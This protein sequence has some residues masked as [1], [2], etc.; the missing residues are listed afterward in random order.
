MS[1]NIK[2][3][4]KS[5]WR[6][7]LVHAARGYWGI[8]I[9][10][11]LLFLAV[12]SDGVL[13]PN[14]QR[15]FIALFEQTPDAY[16]SFVMHA[17]PTVLLIVVS[18]ILLD[19][20][21]I[22]RSLTL[23]HWRPKIHNQIS[24]ILTGYVQQQ[25]M[26]YWTGRMPGK[27]NSQISYVADGF[28]VISNFM[29]MIGASA[30]I[31][32]NVGLILGINA[33]VA[34]IFAFV[35]VF[36]LIYGGLLIRPMG[37][38]AKEASA[39]GSHLS[40]K[41]VDS[42]SNYS[43]VKLFAG[44]RAEKRYLAEP[45]QKRI[46][47]QMF[48]MFVQRLFWAVPTLVWDIAFGCTMLLC[49]WLFMQG[50]ILVSEIVFTTSVFFSVMGT[51]SRIVNQIPDIVDKLGSAK[52]AYDELNIALT[53]TDADNA[54]ALHVTHGKIEFR[55]VW[56]KYKSK[57]VLRDF[58]LTIKPGESVGIVGASG[59]GKTTLVNLLMRFYDPT[60][61]EILIDG[62]N[63][64]DVS[65]DS[66]REN[67][68]F[69]PQEPSMFNRTLRENIGYGRMD[70]T[71]AQ[72]RHAARQ[73]AAHEFIMATD[74]KY[75]SL[76]GDRGIKLSGG[77]RQRIAIARAFLKDAPIL[78]LDEATSAL[79]SETEVAIQKSFE[80]LADGRTTIAIAHRLSTLRNMDR[81][82][83]MQNGKIIEQGSHRVLSR[84]RG[85]YARLWKMQSGGF[86]QE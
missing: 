17:L 3:L 50:R 43:I 7:Y 1:E 5:L 2:S 71:D 32:V 18:L 44:I 72:I 24:E 27:I 56:F 59:A 30:V 6:F 28:S 75:D 10:W 13:F 19:V 48:A 37:N 84:K 81:I 45:R 20:C 80:E 85:E 26:S 8:L 78:V 86:I 64:R 76:V 31:L 29:E 16:S 14:F 79:D 4:P 57:W 49:V 82:V 25:S 9:I 34:V 61:G 68:S 74:K 62:Q 66:L 58:N 73:A 60:R 23:S 38:A 21:A 33:Y 15:M 36:R 40:G 77:Q 22:L 69:I 41:L 55:N 67:I 47:A 46:K 51:I 42:L 63:I 70:A 35:F 52:K 54:P 65:Q 39:A 12:M 53:I 11:A 83:V